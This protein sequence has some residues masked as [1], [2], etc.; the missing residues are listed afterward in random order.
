MSEK[1]LKGC[2]LDLWGFSNLEGLRGHSI[3]VPIKTSWSN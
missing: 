1:D 2:E 3:A